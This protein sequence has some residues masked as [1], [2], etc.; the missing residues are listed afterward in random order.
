MVKIN[1]IT[2]S[3]VVVYSDLVKPPKNPKDLKISSQQM[4]QILLL[5]K[6]DPKFL[7][8]VAAKYHYINKTKD[9][10]S[11]LNLITSTKNK[12]FHLRELSSFLSECI[13]DALNIRKKN[14]K[15]TEYVKNSK[16]EN[17]FI[18]GR[19]NEIKLKNQ[20]NQLS[21]ALLTKD[22]KILQLRYNSLLLLQHAVY[23]IRKGI[24]NIYKS[25]INGFGL[26]RKENKKEIK[27][28]KK[29]IE[30][31]TGK[32]VKKL[33]PEVLSLIS[34]KVSKRFTEYYRSQNLKTDKE[35]ESHVLL[36]AQLFDKSL[37]KHTDDTSITD[38]L[39]GNSKLKENKT[40]QTFIDFFSNIINYRSLKEEI[41]VRLRDEMSQIMI[42]NSKK[43]EIIIKEIDEQKSKK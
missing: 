34:K 23:D 8:I 21:I 13:P 31:Q 35:V 5:L 41:Q 10:K 29:L 20:V 11:C 30:L 2:S 22:K 26:L 33:T 15:V 43:Q 40:L 16:K 17:T 38:I 28:T 36:L 24:E 18:M 32:V 39:N 14:I 3:P 42:E 37:R 7:N 4:N 25:L 27:I 6:A 12:I 9:K 19:S 1:D